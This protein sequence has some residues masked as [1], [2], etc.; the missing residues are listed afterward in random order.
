MSDDA[1]D[2]LPPEEPAPDA[3]ATD[4]AEGAEPAGSTSPLARARHWGGRLVSELAQL[5]DTLERLRLGAADFQLVG[6]RL[7][8]SSQALE[9]L[10]RLYTSTLGDGVRRSADAVNNVRTQLERMP[11]VSPDA[12]SAAVSEFQKTMGAFF[13]GDR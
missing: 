3:A 4:T 9:E 12:F 7:K 1:Q 13:R 2:E 5:P 6:Q 11:Q 8:A 10:T